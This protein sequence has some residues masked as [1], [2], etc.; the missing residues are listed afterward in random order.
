METTP[1]R[2]A[3]AASC[4][5]PVRALRGG[6]ALSWGDAGEEA[7][8]QPSLRLP[9]PTAGAATSAVTSETTGLP[10]GALAM[11]GRGPMGAAH[12]VATMPPEASS[13]AVAAAHDTVLVARY[14]SGQRPSA[15]EWRIS[16]ALR[17]RFWLCPRCRIANE[18]EMSTCVSCHDSRHSL[19]RTTAGAELEALDK[20]T[21][22]TAYGRDLVS[23]SLTR[24]QP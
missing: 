11:A 13:R 24:L 15:G 12:A 19:L 9:A 20:Y 21:Q 7:Q 1:Q 23:S 3:T 10:S 5:T 6:A 4:S 17:L 2:P 14:T 8:P 16:T 22:H 18:A